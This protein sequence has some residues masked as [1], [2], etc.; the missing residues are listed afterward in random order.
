MKVMDVIVDN[1]RYWLAIVG[2][3]FAKSLDEIDVSRITSL[4]RSYEGKEGFVVLVNSNYVSSLQHLIVATVH[5]LRALLRNR[6]RAKRLSIEYLLWVGA[7]KQIREVVNVV[8]VTRGSRDYILVSIASS[9]DKVKLLCTNVIKD[10]GTVTDLEVLDPC[11]LID[12]VL[13]SEDKLRNLMTW[14]SISTK[15]LEATIGS[16][17]E[18]VMKIVVSRMAMLASL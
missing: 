3:R 8:G 13:H 12:E 15:E 16:I 1:L 2:I 4:L 9:Q 17:E 7:R 18:K 11:K 6:L 14:F 5:T 10:L